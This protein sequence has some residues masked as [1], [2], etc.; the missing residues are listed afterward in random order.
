MPDDAATPG[1]PTAAGAPAAAGDSHA[2]LTEQLRSSI[3]RLCS[4]VEARSD[5]VLDEIAHALR[6]VL[7]LTT[8]THDHARSQADRLAAL[9]RD[10]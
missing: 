4:D 7:R 10:A 5:P 2:A 9:E 3:A 6:L 8:H 1:N